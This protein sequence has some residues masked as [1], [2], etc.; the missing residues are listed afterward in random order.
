[1]MATIVLGETPKEDDAK[2]RT[3]QKSFVLVDVAR[4]SDGDNVCRP[5]PLMV[6]DRLAGA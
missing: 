5:G 3:I 1:M 6:F 2:L 4:V